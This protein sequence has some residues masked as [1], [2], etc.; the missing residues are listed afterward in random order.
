MSRF[1]HPRSHRRAFPVAVALLLALALAAPVL[2]PPGQPV[3]AAPSSAGN[4][5]GHTNP[6]LAN[7]TLVIARD[8][9]DAITLDPQREFEFT[10]GF[11]CYNV[12]DTLVTHKSAEDLN[13]FVPVLAKSWTISSD[14]TEYTFQLR[15]D[16]KFASGN[17]LTA[18]DV[19]F[20][21][22]RL[23]NLKGNP[24]WMADHIKD[25]QVVDATT[26]KTILDESVADWLAI[27]SGPN[28]SIVDSKLA[29][30]HG[31]TDAE[32]ASQTDTSEEWFNQNSAGSGPFVLRGWQKNDQISLEANPNYFMGAPKLR[33][34]EIRDVPSPATQK[35]QIESGDVDVAQSLTPDLIMAMM[36]NPSVNIVVGQT[37]SN[38]YMGL[39]MNPDINQYLAR[40][41]VRQAIRAAVD[42]DGVMALANYQ[43]VRGPAVYSVGILGLTQA[44]ADRIN[45]KYD[46][47][48]ARQLL[49]SAGLS[50]GFS[51]E[52]EYGTGPSPT[53]VTYESIAQK[54]QSDL[55]AVNIDARLVPKEF[56]VM[57]TNYRAKKS[58][59]VVSWNDPDYLGAS[60]WAGQMV[61][62]TWAPRLYFDSPQAKDLTKR[63][64][65]ATDQQQRIALYQQLLQLLVD[66]GPYVM[67]L[68]PK[69]Q[70]AVG[71][72]V[73]GYSYFP[74]G[75]VRL[76]DVSKQ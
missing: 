68:Q 75:N 39:T 12:Y 30:E 50:G 7:D 38:M 58:Q 45:P 29:R 14:G 42:Y 51:F 40:K 5:V 71:P 69:T 34:I 10:A 24:S 43:A 18:E 72:S 36:N 28:M 16:V 21:L 22:R 37:L 65:A 62:H 64:D 56:S 33:R 35:L 59:A 47:G 6:R 54:L 76:Y 55:R 17:P 15:D 1:S 20:S 63:A 41:E 66:E 3:Q 8:Q 52:L 53:G 73:R 49:D 32:D 70:I 4:V 9:S 60:D 23:K 44:D 27:L 13:T 19:R 31:A 67:L 26:V 48:R 61:L 57:L 2:A 25:V 11:I 74:L 46:V